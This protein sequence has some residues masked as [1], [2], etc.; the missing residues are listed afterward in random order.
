MSSSS[1]VSE[2]TFTSPATTVSAA[3]FEETIKPLPVKKG[4]WSA[5]SY[6]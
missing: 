5:A 4:N 2:A 6:N 1:N 3:S